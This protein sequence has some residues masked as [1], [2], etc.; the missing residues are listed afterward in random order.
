MVS[1]T[2]ETGRERPKEEEVIMSVYCHLVL[3]LAE[4]KE[5]VGGSRVVVEGGYHMKYT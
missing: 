4:M 3:E 2:L 5:G 1:D